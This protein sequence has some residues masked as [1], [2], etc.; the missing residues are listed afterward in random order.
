MSIEQEKNIFPCAQGC[1]LYSRSGSEFIFL[2]GSGSRR[3]KT[4]KCQE[5]G[6]N[7]NFIKYCK[8]GSASL[9]FNF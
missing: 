9:V 6:S 8:L 2:P 4:E 3:E 1:T 5:I 7:C